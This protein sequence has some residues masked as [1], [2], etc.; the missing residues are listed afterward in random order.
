M[1]FRKNTREILRRYAASKLGHEA[2]SFPIELDEGKR[3]HIHLAVFDRALT[4]VRVAVFPES[5]PL[6]EW[7]RR[8][9]IFH[10]IVGGFFMRGR[11]LPVGE[12]WM[13]GQPVESHLGPWA[14][15]RGTLSV[16]NGEVWIAARRELPKHPQGDLIQAG[17]TLLIGGR[18]QVYPGAAL[19][20]FPETWRRTNDTDITKGRYQRAA[21]GLS[22]DR[23]WVLACDGPYTVPKRLRQT[24][25]DAGLTIGELAELF[26]E[27]GCSDALNLDGGGSTSLVHRGRLVNRP[28]AG[29]RDSQTPGTVLSEGRKVHSAIAFLPR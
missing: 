10:A 24:P 25:A 18:S 11:G 26:V 27:L 2:L 29:I 17:P 23:I 13:R 16:E 15:E 6:T 20:G 28:R 8:T 19:D 3:T 22:D 1:A 4:A 5:E 7:C 14:D 21:I 9:Q 12:V